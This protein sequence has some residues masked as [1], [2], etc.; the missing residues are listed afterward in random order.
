MSFLVSVLTVTIA[1][2]WQAVSHNENTKGTQQL[3]ISKSNT[4]NK[5]R[6][7]NTTYTDCRTVMKFSLLC[8]VALYR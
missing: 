5:H 6:L 2:L 4:L 3:N 8:A 1:W 7:L